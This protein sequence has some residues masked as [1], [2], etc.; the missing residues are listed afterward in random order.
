MLM[1]YGHP[2]PSASERDE[3]GVFHVRH[4][5]H[6]FKYIGDDRHLRLLVC[7]IVTVRVCA[8]DEELMKN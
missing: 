1:D 2:H 5:S 7:R 3:R 8:I 4:T 6:H